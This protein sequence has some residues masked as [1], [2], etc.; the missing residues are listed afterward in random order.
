MV[1]IGNFLVCLQYSIAQ[2]RKLILSE[3]DFFYHKK[4]AAYICLLYIQKLRMALISSTHSL[5]PR[6]ETQ[7]NIKDGESS[8]T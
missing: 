8:F 1:S 4:S 3:N 6:N 7:S 2:L 5:L